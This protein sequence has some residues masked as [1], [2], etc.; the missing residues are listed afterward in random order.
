MRFKL[1][2]VI[3]IAVWALL[4]NR[5]YE[6][7]I[8]SNYYY[9]RLAK[10]NIEKKTYLKP[11]RG[12]ILDRNGELLANNIIGFS[13][14]IKPHMNIKSEDLIRTSKV[15]Y[16]LFF[17]ILDEKLLVKVYKKKNSPYNPKYITGNWIFIQAM[18]DMD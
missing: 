18:R 4:I 9:E 8:K 15:N 17:Q 11:I 10:E 2:I 7:S 6:I 12:E 13:L 3:M 5:L 1:I 14:S 16:R